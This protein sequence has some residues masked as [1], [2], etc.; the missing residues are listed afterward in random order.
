MLEKKLLN[1]IQ[2]E[3]LIQK[4]DKVLVAFSGGPD[5]SCLLH[6]LFSLQKELDIE[7]YT[8]HLN[9]Q[10]RGV[11]AH[12]DALFAY[13][14][15]KTLGIPCFLKS[16]NVP[17]I[18]EQERMTVE[19]AAR[20]AR[21]EMLFDLKEKL[22][23]DKIAVAHNLDDQAETVLMR[24]MRGT[25]LNGLKGMSY[26]RADGVIRPLMDIKRHEIEEYCV[27]KNV[28]TT[29]DKTNEE[30]EYTRN[31]IRLQL[32]PHIEENYSSNIKEI[33]SRMANTLR[34]DSDYI[35]NIARE[36]YGNLGQKHEGYA[37][38]F[39][40]ESIENVPA[41]IQ[42]RIIKEAYADLLGSAEGLEAIHLD[43]ATKLIQNEKSETKINLPKGIIAEKKGY[44]FYVTQK[45]IEVK[46]INF[47]YK[48]PMNGSIE[49]PE[50]GIIIETKIMSK[51]RCKLLPTRINAKAFDLDAMEGDL[52]VRNRQPGDKIRPLGLGGTKKL[53]DIFI[54]KKIP[55][56]ERETVP[57]ISD[58]SKIIW[59]VG[60]EMAEDAKIVEAT[61]EVVRVT[62]KSIQK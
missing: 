33:L 55:R 46:T 20:K 32:L 3:M 7:L 59:I 61:K 43:D 15:S 8:A 26:K 21:Y 29:L 44:N 17:Q 54:D 35:D 22:N 42:K 41:P 51:D 19:E 52:I 9:H 23:L 60:H 47:E 16:V 48:I 4:G 37:I 58:Q 28:R 2:R 10:I 62:V 5:S 1:T 39:D 57:I 50:L 34:E 56:E 53:K 6:L 40:L 25:G 30:E 38:K 27:Q 12:T 24:I 36:L 45:A 11:D 18:A 31:K 13:E 14:E 49:I